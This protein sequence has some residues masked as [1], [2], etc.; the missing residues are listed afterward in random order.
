[1]LAISE[2]LR[3]RVGI[4]LGTALVVVVVVADSKDSRMVVATKRSF[5][6]AI[7]GLDGPTPL[8][9]IVFQVP[10]TIVFQYQSS[11]ELRGERIF[12]RPNISVIPI[13]TPA[14]YEILVILVAHV[15]PRGPSPMGTI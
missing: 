7:D 13:R 12:K 15:C 3:D 11:T 9:F 5:L 2:M 14:V 4:R 1:M 6:V 10:K 8:S